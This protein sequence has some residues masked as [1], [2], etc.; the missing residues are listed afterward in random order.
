M[1]ETSL[2]PPSSPT[3][4]P[5]PPPPPKVQKTTF[6]YKT[7]IKKSALDAHP[8][9]IIHAFRTSANPSNLNNLTREEQCFA[10]ID[11]YAAIEAAMGHLER[12]GFT[13]DK[14]QFIPYSSKSAWVT[15]YPHAFP[16]VH[17]DSSGG[18]AGFPH[19]SP[20]AQSELDI[21]AEVV[22]YVAT[23]PSTADAIA[24][25]GAPSAKA[26]AVASASTAAKKRGNRLSREALLSNN[27]RHALH[28]EIYNYFA[29]L[30]AQVTELETSEAGRR[31]VKKADLPA[32]GLRALLVKL[33]T[34][35]KVVGQ[36]KIQNKMKASRFDRDG[37]GDGDVTMGDGNNSDDDDAPEVPL[38]EESLIPEMGKLA[39][40]EEEAR[41]RMKA[42]IKAE[43]GT[44]KSFNASGEALDFDTMFEKLLEYK[45]QYGHPNVPV[46]YSDDLQLGSWVSGLRTKKK[47]YDKDPEVAMMDLDEEGWSLENKEDGQNN[48]NQNQKYLNPERIQRLESI[49]FA[50]SMAKPKAKP[51]SWDERLVQLQE[52][53][54]EHG[55]WKVPRAT[56]L[57]EWL[58]NQ[59]TLYAKK[60]TKFMANK[61][62]RLEEIGYMFNVKENSS[63]SWDD[64]FQQLVEYLREHGNFDVPWPGVEEENPNPTE[65][66][67]E[68]YRFYKWVARLHNEYRA[69]E[70]GTHSKLNAERV[71]KLLAINF[72]FRGPKNR[73][74]P[75]TSN[76]VAVP[77]IAWEKRI[78]QLE[79]FKADTGHLHID[80]N[81]RHCSNLGG[82]AAEQSTM[83]RNWKEGT[84]HLSQ[85][86]IAK[87]DQLAAM[88][89][90]F[91]IL[92]YYENNRSWEDHFAVLLKF[93]EQNNGSARVP[94]K[95]KADLR[96]GKWVQ[97]QRQQ[98]K[99]WQDEKKNKLTEDKVDRLNRVGFEWEVAGAG[100]DQEEEEV[101]DE[102]V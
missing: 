3:P 97:T 60:D 2:P 68:R 92:P 44:R 59:R 6:T 79:N 20:A 4:P 32:A 31:S 63:V 42:K 76:L 85:D 34:T 77:K 69:F 91:N 33:E 5:P 14:A 100:A 66:D 28:L 75:S 70:K 38:L 17:C 54:A 102:Q 11:A 1:E 95:Y 94:L 96:L 12:Y 35:F 74:R 62:P 93:K 30:S 90:E 57:G 25:S 89:F 21:P 48:I 51:K 71:E 52:W 15:K 23:R 72:E 36:K 86:M 78:Q 101:E 87:F 88:G 80:H 26:V 64:R 49:G 45:A 67:K 27:E 43:A 46:K 61:A 9:G 39:A 40:I 98:Y 65:A 19:W 29:W 56:S 37:G 18:V 10:W 82:W 24:K 84:Q 53:Y 58:H 41:K 22:H 55:T 81:Y 7:D 50:W 8:C 13:R 83:Y 73:G 47:A 99:L 16:Y